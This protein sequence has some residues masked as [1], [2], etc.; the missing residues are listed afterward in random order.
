MTPVPGGDSIQFQY[1][2]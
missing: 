2:I 1:E